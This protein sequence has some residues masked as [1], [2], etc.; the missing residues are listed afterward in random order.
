[1][2]LYIAGQNREEANEVADACMGRNGHIITS[3]W[4][5]KP[6]NRTHDHTI[7]ERNIIAQED[8]DDVT[9]ADAVVLISCEHRIPSGKFV[10]VGIALGQNKPIYVIGHRE[11]MLMW[12]PSVEQFDNIDEF[13]GAVG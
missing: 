6:F 13:L 2:Y 8:F 10:E 1:M 5:S 3:R 7:P 12:H 4:I 11:N 9:A